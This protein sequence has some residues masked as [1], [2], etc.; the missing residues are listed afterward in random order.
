M[1]I[2]SLLKVTKSFL[3][4]NDAELVFICFLSQLSERERRAQGKDPPPLSG[5]QRFQVAAIENSDSRQYPIDIWLT[6]SS[7]S[8]NQKSV[9]G[10]L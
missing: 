3:G 8:D 9:H 6:E 2:C 4:G 10:S 7:Y 5:E 1:R